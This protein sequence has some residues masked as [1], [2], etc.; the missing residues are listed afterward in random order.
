MTTQVASVLEKLDDR[1]ASDAFLRNALVDLL[2]EANEAKKRE[3][4][5]E[6][7]L[8]GMNISRTFHVH[9]VRMSKTD[10]SLSRQLATPGG[11][12]DGPR[13]GAQASKNS[14]PQ[15]GTA[16]YKSPFLPPGGLNFAAKRAWLRAT[17][18]VSMDGLLTTVAHEL[19][20]VGVFTKSS[21]TAAVVFTT[22]AIDYA[23]HL[24]TQIIVAPI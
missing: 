8:N 4:E 5:G 15:A 22:V 24:S 10:K 20:N 2:K 6:R 11:Q 14:K 16:V 19:S 13:R 23:R 1:E 17:G 18:T 21:P 7:R 9:M 12:V 3:L